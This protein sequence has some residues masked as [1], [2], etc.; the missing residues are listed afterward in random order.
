MY[1]TGAAFLITSRKHSMFRSAFA[2]V[3]DFSF[4]R[5]QTF[6]SKDEDNKDTR[7]AFKKR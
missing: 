1:G 2:N 3:S 6:P 5:P 4:V 7:D